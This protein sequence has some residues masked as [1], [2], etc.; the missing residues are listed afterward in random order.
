MNDLKTNIF[1]VKKV[2]YESFKTEDNFV[3]GLE[4]LHNRYKLGLN[5]SQNERIILRF[6]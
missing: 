6:Y 2:I 1:E 4:K 5:D 3:A